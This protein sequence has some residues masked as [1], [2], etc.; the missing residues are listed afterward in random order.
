LLKDRQTLGPDQPWSWHKDKE[1]KTVGYLTGDG[2]IVP[3]QGPKGAKAE[4]RQANVF[5]IYNPVPEDPAQWAN[6]HGRRPEPQARYLASLDSQPT[7][8][9]P[10]RTQA[11]QVGLEEAER[12]LAITDG[13]SGLEDFFLTNFPRVE[14]VIIDFYHVAEALKELAKVWHGNDAEAGK[15]QGEAWCHDL[16]H[17][18]GQEVYEQLRGL[19]GRGKSVAARGKQEEV[20]TYFGNQVHRMD[21][22][23]YLEKGWQI[24]SGQAESACKSVVGER[25]KRSGMRWGEE[26]T[27]QVCCLRALLKSEP[28]QWRAFWQ[29]SD[30]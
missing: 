29:P 3:Q 5:G 2:T 4:G 20:L 8:G 1:G 11:A 10:L 24:G 23:R 16:K 27:D 12:W 25:L 15:E 30:T 18:G 14:A 21:Y 7:L 9:L 19:E 17:R 26:G 13:G 22:P 6:P 28:S